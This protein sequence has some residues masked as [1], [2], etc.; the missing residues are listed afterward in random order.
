[1]LTGI[2]HIKISLI[3]NIK[4]EGKELSLINNIKWEGKNRFSVCD[5]I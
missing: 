4:W 1:M 5:L 2:Q 3:N